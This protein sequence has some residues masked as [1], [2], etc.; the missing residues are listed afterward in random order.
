MVCWGKTKQGRQRF[1]CQKCFKTCIKK[2]PDQRNRRK[3]VLFERW[4]LETETLKR[5]SRHRHTTASSMIREFEVFWNM[6]IEPLPYQGDE[7]TL[8]VDGIILERGSCILIA[9]DGNGIPITWLACRRENSS[10]WIEL[11][12]LT[13][14]QGMS[15][16]SII[17]S[18]AQKGLI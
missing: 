13:K 18:D 9:I 17:V 15:N 5:I 12:K 11:L 1:R 3:E 7:R 2:H 10:S 16:P 4:L 6:N 8:M 14:K